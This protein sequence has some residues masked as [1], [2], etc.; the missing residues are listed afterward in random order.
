M[1][2]EYFINVLTN[3]FNECCPIRQI[4]VNSNKRKKFKWFTP[5]LKKN[6]VLVQILYDRFKRSRGTPSE[7]KYK[8]EYMRAK[9]EYQCKIK[10]EK[11]LFNENYFNS[12]ANKCKAAWELIK[13]ES[14]NI[15]NNNMINQGSVIN[16]N[17]FNDYF[18]NLVSNLE[19]NNSFK[20]NVPQNCAIDL[21]NK[22]VSSCDKGYDRFSWQRIRELDIMK[23]TTNL[24]SSRSEDYYGFSNK[25]LK[26]IIDIILSPLVFLF[27]K[28]LEQGKY[29]KS[30]KV[31]TVTPIYKRGEKLD[32]SSYRPISLIPIVSKI[33]EGCIKQQLVNFFTKNNFICE[34]QFGF[35]SGRNTTKAVEKLVE[36]VLLNFENKLISSATLIDLTKAFDCISHGL[37]VKKLS[38]YGIEG[39]ELSLFKSYL[40]ERKQMVVQGQDKSDFRLIKAGVPQGSILGPFIFV[41]AI[42]DLAFNVSCTT[43]LYADDTTLLNCEKKLEQLVKI[44]DQAMKEALHWFDANLL[45]VNNGKTEQIIF[46]LNSDINRDIKPVKLLGMFLDSRLSWDFHIDELCKKLSRVIYL[47]RK[48]R[49]CVTFNMLMTAYFALFHSHLRYGITLW[50]NSCGWKKVFIWQKKAIRI[51]QNVPERETCKPIFKKLQIMTLPSLYIFCC[52]V[53]VRESLGSLKVRQEIH[54]YSTRQKHLLDL[55]PLKL[56]KTNS[57]HIIMKLKLFNK[58]PGEA[59]SVPLQRFKKTIGNWLKEQVFYSVEEYLACDA[60]TL[61]LY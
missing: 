3:S 27:N 21:V 14:N 57:S 47:L 42:N 36:Q 44:E 7:N 51:M 22:Y 56:E 55:L 32:P 20:L 53:S 28:I 39:T 9:K 31:S 16:S 1:A 18:V 4:S 23:V 30:F 60:S 17:T 6:K 25:V 24:S 10:K 52:L 29:P 59:W 41:I 34:N 45:L 49:N 37:I 48:L 46:S 61:V 11:L 12:S 26:D 2:C 43:L 35:I 40:K 38:C 13:T 50:G 33:L 54:S 8:K 58:L 15:N 19:S 5:Q